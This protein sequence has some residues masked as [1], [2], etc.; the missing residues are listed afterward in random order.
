MHQPL[1]TRPG[2]DIR[3]SVYSSLARLVVGQSPITR[4]PEIAVLCLREGAGKEELE[5]HYVM[6]PLRPICCPSLIVMPHIN[7]YAA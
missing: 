6:V 7:P 2:S 3:H 4:V 1:N 5:L